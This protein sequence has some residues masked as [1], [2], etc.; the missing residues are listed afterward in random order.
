MRIAIG[1][2]WQE[3]NTL[4]PLATTR[5]DFEQFGI[6]RGDDLVTQ[7]ADVNELGGF[8]QAM[9]AWPG[10]PEIAGLVRL[11]AWPSGTAT[12]E[13]FKWLRREF[14]GAVEAAGNVDA[15]LL[16]LHGAMVAQGQPDVEGAILQELRERS[17]P[18]VPIVA[19]LDL[20]TNITREMVRAADVLV[21][22]HSMPHVDIFETGQRGAEALRRMLFEG[23]KPTTAFCKIPAVVPPENSN[24][25]ADAGIAVELK[26][27]VVE[28]EK[29][30]NILSAGIAPVQP[31]MD[32]P[33]FGS[34]VVVTTDND[35]AAARAACVSVAEEFWRRRREYM[36]TLV[37]VEDAVR[38]A[39]EESGLTVLSD[40]ADATTS[41]AP[42]DSVWILAELLKYR[43][44][45]EALV[46]VVAPEVVEQCAGVVPGTQL[47]VSLGGLRD[48]RFGKSIELDVTVERTF[49][50]R[51]TM[52][53][54]IG[55]NMPIDMGR[56]VVLRHASNTLVIVTTRTGPHFAPEL[57]RAAGFE[58]FEASVVIAKSPCGFRAVYAGHA[59]G[60]YSVKAPGC[61]PSD[62]WNHDFKNIPRPLWPWDDIEQW[63]P[64]EGLL[65]K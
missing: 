49:D 48:N 37:S 51:F 20:H 14:F 45:R 9:R 26:R 22:Y 3:T 42:G 2:L 33:Q 5:A 50:A 29:M 7:M 17:G 18:D 4:N 39:H 24:T 40:A 8:I 6:C 35:P 52:T 31:W 59:A 30:S 46:T 25:E 23:A 1:Q 63:T 34:S 11:P 16:A 65:Q 13:C 54:H 55:K 60:I 61:A 12:A 36:P 47:T 44:P 43:W 32:I 64:A 58:P 19:T 10:P 21:T 15:F 62:F 53:G 41:G 38:L 57:F 28:L 56:S 27:R